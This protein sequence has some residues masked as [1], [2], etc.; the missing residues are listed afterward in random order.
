MSA[1]VPNDRFVDYYALL[2]VASDAGLKQIRTNYIR[3]A[4]SHHPDIGGTTDYMQLLNSAYKTLAGSLSRSAYDRLYELHYGVSAGP[5]FDEQGSFESSGKDIPDDYVD[6]F[7]DK[8][9]A[10]FHHEPKQKTLK[11]KIK[12]IFKH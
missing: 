4:K 2:E 3:L 9:Y 6:Y 12:S 5:K 8:L 10:E 1:T 7:L 11:T